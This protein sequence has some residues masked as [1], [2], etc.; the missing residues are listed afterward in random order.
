M[1]YLY[2]YRR[3]RLRPAA[4]DDD[5]AMTLT[6]IYIYLL[7]NILIRGIVGEETEF[8]LFVVLFFILIQRTD[9]R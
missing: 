9:Y 5:G 8:T 1:T 3:F 2:I 7:F 4:D 6:L